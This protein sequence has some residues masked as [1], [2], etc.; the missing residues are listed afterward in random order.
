MPAGERPYAVAVNP[1]TNKIYVSNQFSNT[2]RIIDG[3]TNA[4]ASLEE[5]SFN[6]IAADS[7]L[8]K[9]YLLGYEDTDLKVLGDGTAMLGRISLGMHQW[10]MAV[11]ENDSTVYVTRIGNAELAMVEERTGA[12]TRI[13]TGAFPCAVQL[14][15][16]TNKI[17]VVNHADDTVTV[18]DAAKRS[19]VATIAVGH[20]PQGIAIDSARNRIYVANRNDNT[21]SVI[22]GRQNQVIDTISVERKPFALAVLPGANQLYAAT[23]SGQPLAVNVTK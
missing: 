17:Y 3:A 5:G 1:A 9:I 11:N 13:P 6:V 12:V 19:V 15:P 23:V 16:M 21:I 20:G 8:G 4:I 22:D 2:V 14:N 10:A 18:I 7:K